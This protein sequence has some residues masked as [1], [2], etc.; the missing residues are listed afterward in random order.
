MASEVFEEEPFALAL[1]ALRLRDSEEA[2]GVAVEECLCLVIV[3]DM[4][5]DGE[6]Y[7]RARVCISNWRLDTRG[8]TRK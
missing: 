4:V 3:F 7:V 8:Q 6:V 1:G 2:V 5:A